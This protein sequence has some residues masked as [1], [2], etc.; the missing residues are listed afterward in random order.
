MNILAKIR[1]NIIKRF[2]LS[3]NLDLIS[4]SGLFDP[5]Y[6]LG[7]NKDMKAAHMNPLK[8]FYFYGWK[9][10][11]NPSQ[12]FNT[13]YYLAA[14]EDVKTSGINPLVHYIKYGKQEGRLP[15]AFEFNADQCL[16]KADIKDIEQTAIEP[17]NLKIAII[18]HLFYLELAEEFIGYFKNN[19]YP[20]D[21]YITTT[22]N[23]EEIIRELFT[24]ALPG[25]NTRVLAIENKGRDIGPFIT[26]LKTHLMKYDLVCKVHSKK[27]GHNVDLKGWRKY[28]LDQLLG[29]PLI[30]NRIISEFIR[31]RQLGIVW[32]VAYPY[33]SYLGLEK[34]WGPSHSGVKNFLTASRYFSELNLDEFG[35]DFTFPLG[36]MFW[37]RPKALELIIQKNIG[38][39]H[40]E[41][42]ENQIDGTL[43]HAFERLF[44]IIPLRAGFDTKTVFFLINKIQVTN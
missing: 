7:T 42:E 10:G 3:G 16:A 25:V 4:Q 27:S 32:P 20:Y 39:T 31:Y 15:K 21:L 12:E 2:T 14:N 41:N 43:A 17:A 33:L 24:T 6:Y 30:I 29:N 28:L 19:P 36:S 26:A 22:H 34:G 5:E 11:M 35:Q 23:Q 37:F 18:C 8:H 40:F 44:G 13:N 38:I 9:E 1:L